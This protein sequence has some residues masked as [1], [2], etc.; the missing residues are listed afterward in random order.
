MAGRG[1]GKT[2]SG[3]EWIHA[4]ARRRRYL[5][6]VAPTLDEVR[7]LQIEGESGLLETAPPWWRPK[8]N[9]NR[10]RLTYPNGARV[11]YYTADEPERLRGKQHEVAWCEEP[12]SWRYPSSWDHLVL[13]LRLGADPRAL[14]TGTPKPVRIIRNLV[15]DP[16]CVVTT[17]TTYENFANLAPA[18][19]EEVIK[20]YEGTRLGDQELLA[21]LL[22]DDQEAVIPRAWVLE[23]C[24]DLPEERDPGTGPV[25]L[26]LDV[27][28]AGADDCALVLRI[29]RRYRVLRRWSEA[30]TM[31]TAEVAA[32]EARV[33]GAAYLNVDSVGIGQGVADRLKELRRRGVLKARVN[34]VNFGA[35]AE[36]P[37]RFANVRAEAWWLGRDLTERGEWDLTHIAPDRGAESLRIG[38]TREDVVDELTAPHYS[39]RAGRVVVEKKEEVKKR[40]GRSPDVADA[41]L[42]A[43][44]GSRAGGGEVGGW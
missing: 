5:T 43:A 13:G 3:S 32:E 9:Q 8:W 27:A 22:E 41:L 29:A 12:G 36:D 44:M 14:I 11:R 20:R 34:A 38:A 10:R 1:F 17:G 35:G 31:R 18:F 21:H 4:E 23:R 37:K 30:D 40:L 2:R 24:M 26:G 42:L 15:A 16:N 7:E 28:G 25:G 19:I 6:L 33:H 39:Y